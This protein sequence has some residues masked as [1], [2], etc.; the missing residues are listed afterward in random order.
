MKFTEEQFEEILEHNKAIYMDDLPFEDQGLEFFNNLPV[1]FQSDAMKWG[2]NDT[3]FRDNLF[4]YLIKNQFG[5]TVDQYY[6]SSL[7]EK[8]SKDHQTIPINYE[9]LKNKKR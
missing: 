8:Y 4:E 5:M 9:Y 1:S 7:F 3:E 6:K 2:V